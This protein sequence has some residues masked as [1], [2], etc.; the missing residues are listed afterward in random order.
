[1]YDCHGFIG[2]R[3][4]TAVAGL[5]LQHSCFEGSGHPENNLRNQV[6]TQ[7]SVTSHHPQS[8]GSGAFSC[9]QPN[10]LC[11]YTGISLD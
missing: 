7:F 9:V 4:Q 3:A 1:M 11:Q 6:N 5:I 10:H 8:D 2:F